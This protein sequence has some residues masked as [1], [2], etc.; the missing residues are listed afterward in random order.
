M[1]SSRTEESK[2]SRNDL[3]CTMGKRTLQ[4]V[5]GGQNISKNLWIQSWEA[6]LLSTVSCINC[7]CNRKKKKCC[8]F[9]FPQLALGWKG[10]MHQIGF[11][12]GPVTQFCTNSDRFCGKVLCYIAG[13]NIQNLNTVSICKK[14]LLK[15][16]LKWFWKLHF[17]LH[18]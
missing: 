17:A 12:Q 13:G 6:R 18:H 3:W 15:V 11:M 5:L 9:P 16:K 4:W 1:A 14:H 2:T 7:S 8:T 10:A